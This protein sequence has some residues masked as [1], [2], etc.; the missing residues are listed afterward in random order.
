MPVDDRERLVEP[1]LAFPIEL[2][3]GAPQLG[4]AL[5]QIITLGGKALELL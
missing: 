2:L 3:D 1:R 4:D 5:L